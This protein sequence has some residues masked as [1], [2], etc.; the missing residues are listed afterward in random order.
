MAEV[1]KVHDSIVEGL[2]MTREEEWKDEEIQRLLMDVKASIDRYLH[3]R[4]KISVPSERIQDE[5][6]G[7]CG[8]VSK[9]DIHPTTLLPT[10][11]GLITQKEQPA[12]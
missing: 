3:R 1:S 5:E 2:G 9:A 6:H 10:G 11:D 7:R 12:A 4:V 8:G